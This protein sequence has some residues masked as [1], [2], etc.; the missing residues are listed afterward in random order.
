MYRQ[1]VF[2]TQGGRGWIHRYALV[3]FS[4]VGDVAA[5]GGWSREAGH[6]HFRDIV[7]PSSVVDL[8]VYPVGVWIKPVGPGVYS[9]RFHAVESA[10]IAPCV[11]PGVWIES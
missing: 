10:V 4:Q 8:V 7:A 11:F 2:L 1:V 3:A 6:Q 5:N 9:G